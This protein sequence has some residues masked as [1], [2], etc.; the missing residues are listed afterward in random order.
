[1]N[2][3]IIIFIGIFVLIVSVTMIYLYRSSLSA[4]DSKKPDTE[5]KKPDTE[6]KNPAWI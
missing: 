6:S 1:M 3:N 4:T 5:S 2:K